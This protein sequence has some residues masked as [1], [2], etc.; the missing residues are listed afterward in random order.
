MGNSL[1]SHRINFEDLQYY[2]KSNGT[3]LNLFFLI[4]VLDINEQECLIKGTIPYDKEEIVINKLLSDGYNK[5]SIIIVY[6]KNVYDDNVI[7]K[8]NQLKN[9]GFTK[10]YVYVSGLFEW[11]LLQD[12]YGIDE[13]PTTTKCLDILK[14]KPLPSLTEQLIYNRI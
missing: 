6:G 13:F 12:I 14:Y 2:I 9:L 11:L 5:Q 3:T 7:K 1:T 8:I 4:N 10:T